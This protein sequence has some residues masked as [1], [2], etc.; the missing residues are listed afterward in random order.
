MDADGRIQKKCDMRDSTV[1]RG[2]CSIMEAVKRV[3][4][5]GRP[6]TAG[7]DPQGLMLM[8]ARSRPAAGPRTGLEMPVGK[9]NEVSLYARGALYLRI[10]T[11]EVH[12]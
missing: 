12:E 11:C 10:S 7:A 9:V 4:D 2:S 8:N 1:S 3:G 6:E 5:H